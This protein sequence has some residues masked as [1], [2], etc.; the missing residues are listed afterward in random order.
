LGAALKELELMTIS[1]GA[2]GVDSIAHTIS[3]RMGL[4]TIAILPSG[5]RNIYPSSLREIVNSIIDCGGAVISEFSSDQKMQK[6]FFQ[7]RNRLIPAF[8]LATLVVEARTRS[9]TMITAQESIEQSKPLFVLPSH[10]MDA[11]SSGSLDLICDGAT[12]VRDAK[13][14]ILY[15]RSEKIHPTTSSAQW[16]SLN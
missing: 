13:D 2:R 7:K 11:N 14:L 1:G 6:H 16:S 9:G 4:P 5:M 15:L 10:P 8:A 12:P 3:I